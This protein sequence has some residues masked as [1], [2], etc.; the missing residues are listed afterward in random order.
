MKGNR[1]RIGRDI[2]S[3]RV[4]RWGPFFLHEQFPMT[5]RCKL[6]WLLAALCAVGLLMVGIRSGA[7]GLLVAHAKFLRI[8][9]REGASGQ[10]RLVERS[11]TQGCWGLEAGAC[12]EREALP[13]EG[14][15]V[16]SSG[17]HAQGHAAGLRWATR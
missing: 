4:I 7:M 6:S 8:N 15:L 11:V 2:S 9:G 17:G 13:F 5:S 3:N 14:R 1:R 12:M 16:V 10:A